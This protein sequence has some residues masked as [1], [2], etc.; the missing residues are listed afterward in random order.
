MSLGPPPPV[1]VPTAAWP[2]FVGVALHRP[3][4]AAVPPP[5][6]PI[7]FSVE[8]AI[9]QPTAPSVPQPVGVSA[10][11]VS[12]YSQSVR[13]PPPPL[14]RVP[15]TPPVGVSAPPSMSIATPAPWGTGSPQQQR[16]YAPEPTPVV[17]LPQPVPKLSAAALASAPALGS[18]LLLGPPQLPLPLPHSLALPT[19][20][21]SQQHVTFNILP[22]NAPAAATPVAQAAPTSITAP[23]SGGGGVTPRP[24]GPSVWAPAVG[25]TGPPST[26]LSP[27]SALSAP[28]PAFAIPLSQTAPAVLPSTALPLTSPVLAEVP[29][30]APPQGCRE[31][32]TSAEVPAAECQPAAVALPSEPPTGPHYGAYVLP[33][34]LNDAMETRRVGLLGLQKVPIAMNPPP[35]REFEGSSA[36]QIPAPL[37]PSH[38]LFGGAKYST[39][40]FPF[41]PP[42]RTRERC[43]RAPTTEDSEGRHLRFLR[44]QLHVANKY[45]KIDHSQSPVATHRD[46]RPQTSLQDAEVAPVSN[47]AAETIDLSKAN[48]CTAAYAGTLQ[49]LQAALEAAKCPNVIHGAGY[50]SVGRRQWG[51]K[52]QGSKYILGLGMKA[53][54]LQFAA[55]ARRLD[56]IVFLLT[57]GARDDVA[58]HMQEML[59]KDVVDIILC[60]RGSRGASTRAK[61]S[62]EDLPEVPQSLSDTQLPIPVRPAGEESTATIV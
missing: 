1:A 40:T 47:P 48:L 38:V 17:A 44:E 53:T 32:T 13:V 43:R 23:V 50:V 55:A 57:N 30:I 61:P 41:C 15:A 46:A 42:S 7:P 31:L 37:P 62:K 10:A 36:E 19:Q 3:S 8:L 60:G 27:P 11:G 39:N 26:M 16:P 6:L 4:G 34:V 58:P 18:Q 28:S 59:P 22:Q 33:K 49:Q 20:G 5:A 56:N 52:R 24:T 14:M 21:P 51:L 45:L 9:P 25:P 35:F 29:A 12:P 2:Q 54:P